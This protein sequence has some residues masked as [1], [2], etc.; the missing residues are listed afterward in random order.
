MELHLQS[1]DD[2]WSRG[3]TK[4]VKFLRWLFGTAFR[5]LTRL[6]VKGLENIP[7]SGPYIL[8]ANHMSR[9][10]PI[11]LY[12]FFGTENVTGWVAEK[13]R[14]NPFF[15]WIVNLSN[16]IFIRRGEVDRNALDAAVQAL[17]SEMVF[18]LAPEGTRSRVGS[19]IR[20]KTGIAYLADL[21]GA[22][23]LPIA[24]TG[25]D[26]LFRDLLRFRRPRLTLQIGEAFHLPPLDQDDRTAA[27]RRNTDE[28]MCRIAA[29]LPA[30]YRGFYADHHKLKEIL[31]TQVDGT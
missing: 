4:R 26:T 5:L 17:N 20:A 2:D 10:D 28:V 30:K 27:L 1:M 24:I 16:P 8:A 3:L 19:L 23:V 15:N 31:A 6:E 18:G 22:A 14:H 21:S 13:Y 29:M 12:V 7:P 25:T 11:L 9:A